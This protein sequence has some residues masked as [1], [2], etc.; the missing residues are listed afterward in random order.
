[1]SISFLKNN[2]IDRNKWDNLIADA[3]NNNIYGYSWFLDIIAEKWNALV[4]DDYQAVMPLPFNKK[5]LINYIY[6]PTHLQKVAI[7]SREPMDKASISIFLSKI[8][9]K[10][11]LIDL[12]I[13]L[14]DSSFSNAKIE[15]MKNYLLYLNT[16]Y[17]SIYNNFRRNTKRNIDKANSLVTVKKTDD[18]SDFFNTRKKI[19]LD[20][21]KNKVTE[22]DYEKLYKLLNYLKQTNRLLVYNAYDENNFFCAS[23]CF[24]LNGKKVV[25]SHIS[26]DK[27]VS[28]NANYA[29]VNEFI[30]DHSEKDLTLDFAGSNVKG[31]EYFNSGFGSTLVPY[32]RYFKYN[33]KFL[34]MCLKR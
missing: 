13:D 14:T 27:G 8:P 4:L 10:F 15:T 9:H 30:K 3:H 5:F 33:W 11:A 21:L 1:M 25:I 34:K 23:A 19:I 32:S 20:R 6:T 17:K 26:N 12:R 22:N 29:I 18:F 31:I 24:F 7:Y 2:E 28:I 16:E